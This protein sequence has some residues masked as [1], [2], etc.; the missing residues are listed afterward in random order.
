M[1]ESY[2][3]DIAD[4][5]KANGIDDKPYFTWWVHYTLR[6]RDVIMY[7]IKLRV[8]KT[9]HKYGIKIPMSVDHVYKTNKKNKDKLWRNAIHKEMQNV[10]IDFE[11]I[12]CNQHVKV[13][14]KKSTRHMVF[15]VKIDFTRN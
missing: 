1:K 7:S 2:P 12:Y 8:I 10:R 4:F 11:I 14:W 6:K 15:G 9:M 5:S 13:G 3:I